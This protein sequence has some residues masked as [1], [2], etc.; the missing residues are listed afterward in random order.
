[1]LDLCCGPGRHSTG[2]A[3]RGFQV[4]GV[5]RSRFLLSIARE[6]AHAANVE[7]EWVDEDMR[8]FQRPAAFDLACSLFTFFGYFEDVQDDL[9]VL[10]NVHNSLVS[11]GVFVL[12]LTGKERVARTWQSVMCSKLEDGSLVFQ[13][14]E[15]RADWTR[16]R[17][18]WVVAKDGHAK[19]FAF[20][21]T[22]YSG[23]EL[24]DLLLASGFF[25]VALYG[26][27]QGGP[28]GL[29]SVRLVAVAHKA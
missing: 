2:F 25:R 13:R 12:E 17:N 3:Q 1:V 6:R 18:D 7:V 8:S 29:G 15:V 22:I 24:R 20:E 19:S 16:I 5:D 26:D 9:R 21:H 14:P 4:T 27:M 10:R 28:Y 23:R 11:G